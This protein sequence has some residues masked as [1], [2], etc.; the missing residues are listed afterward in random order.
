MSKQVKPLSA[1]AKRAYEML[2]EFGP[3]TVAEMKEKGFAEANS[4]H[5]VAL[6]R[7]GMIDSDEITVEVP[8]VVKRKVQLYTVVKND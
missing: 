6:K 7:R 3:L 1:G 2:K 4:A 8:T 5:L